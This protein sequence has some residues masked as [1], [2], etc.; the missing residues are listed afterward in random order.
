MK[1]QDLCTIRSGHSFRGG[2]VDD[3]DGDVSIIQPGNISSNGVIS[4]DDSEPLKMDVPTA[5]F[6]QPRDV[7]VVNRGRFAAAVFDLSDG[8]SWIAPSSIIVLTI[9]KRSVL[10]EYLACYLNSANGQKMF[11][12]H[13]EQT[14]IPYI[15]IKNLGEMEMPVPPLDRQRAVVAFA[16]ATD[17]YRQ[18][19]RRKQEIFQQMINHSLISKYTQ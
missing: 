9:N 15:S 18:L 7:L 5:K 2:L 3:P 6:L 1:I 14:T 19:T 11:Q 8:K 4:F 13:Y 16:Q 10:P 17:K 12:R